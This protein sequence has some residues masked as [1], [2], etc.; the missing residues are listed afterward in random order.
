[1]IWSIS[2]KNRSECRVEG[3]VGSTLNRELGAG[4]RSSYH[5][6]DT[7]ELNIWQKSLPCREGTAKQGPECLDSHLSCTRTRETSDWTPVRGKWSAGK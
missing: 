7:R 6:V 4:S 5:P 2:R 1:M 3:A